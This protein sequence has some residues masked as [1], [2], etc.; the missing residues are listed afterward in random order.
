MTIS[1]FDAV[2]TYWQTLKE[3]VVAMI[4]WPFRKQDWDDIWKAFKDL[5]FYAVLG[6]ALRLFLLLTLPVSAPVFAYFVQAERRKIA[7][8][9]KAMADIR[10]NLRPV[11]T[12]GTMHEVVPEWNGPFIH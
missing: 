5:M 4:Q 2:M 1:N 7:A 9:I 10:M 3:I 8:R 6:P 12:S 11:G